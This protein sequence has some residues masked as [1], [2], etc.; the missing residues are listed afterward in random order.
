MSHFADIFKKSFL[1]NFTSTDIGTARIL[2]TLTVTAVIGLYIFA[3]YRIV[4]RKT[5]YSKTFNISLVALALITSAIILAMQS[6]LV[7]SLGMVGAL[8]IIR[9]RTAIKD[10]MDLVFLFWSISIGII[11]GAGLYEI[12]LIA[13]VLVTVAI[14]ALDLFPTSRAAMMLVVNANV[15]EAEEEIMAVVRKLSKNSKVKSRNFSK[16][17]LD[18]VVEVHVKEEAELVKQVAAI[19]AVTSVSLISHDGEVTF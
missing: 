8:S 4:T 13:S 10:P 3:I 17:H 11:C 6:N 2:L 12:A 7:I 5:F 1:Q 9:F 14:I 16:D 15:L 19:G 18:M